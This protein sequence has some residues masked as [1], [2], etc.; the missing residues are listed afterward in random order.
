MGHPQDWLSGDLLLPLWEA[1]MAQGGGKEGFR[2]QRG[3]PRGEGSGTALSFS[4][5]LSSHMAGDGSE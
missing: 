1:V 2:T 5:N 4:R 3:W